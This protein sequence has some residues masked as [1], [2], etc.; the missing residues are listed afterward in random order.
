M[1]ISISVKRHHFSV[2]RHPSHIRVERGCS[3]SKLFDGST[4]ARSNKTRERRCRI[5]RKEKGPKANQVLFIAEMIDEGE[6][7]MKAFTSSAMKLKK[8]R[9][10]RYGGVSI[11]INTLVSTDIDAR[12]GVEFISLPTWAQKSPQITKFLMDYIITS[13][14]WGVVTT[15]L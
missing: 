4:T 7:F 12:R 11:D 3:V 15:W 13:F 14:Y 9:C 10:R 2:H 8:V 5:G 1:S 6:E